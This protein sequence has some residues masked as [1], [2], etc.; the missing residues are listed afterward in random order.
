MANLFL[1]VIYEYEL[2]KEFVTT[3]EPYQWYTHNK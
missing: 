3:E 2:K 1:I